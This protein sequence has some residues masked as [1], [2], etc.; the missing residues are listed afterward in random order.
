MVGNSGTQIKDLFKI[1]ASTTIRNYPQELFLCLQQIKEN[2]DSEFTLE[3]CQKEFHPH[4]TG[5]T[6]YQCKQLKK[7]LNAGWNNHWSFI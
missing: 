6:K 5:Y 2:G 3:N 4:F 1:M 7:L